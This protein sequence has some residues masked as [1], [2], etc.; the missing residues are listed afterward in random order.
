VENSRAAAAWRN[1]KQVMRLPFDT[2]Q[3]CGVFTSEQA[4]AAGWTKAQLSYAVRRDRIDRLRR[5]VYQAV[6]AFALSDHERARWVHA[7]QAIGAVLMTPGSAASHSAAAALRRMP[8]LF[9]PEAACMTVAPWFTGD[10][11]RVHVHR[12]GSRPFSLPVGS[13]ACTRVERTAID[14]AREHG[15]TAG[16]VALDYA[17]HTGMTD[18][19]KVLEDLE[20]CAR[21]PG[22]RQAREA[23]SLADGRS[24][25]VLESRSRLKLRE[26][27]VPEPDLQRSIGNEWG[28]FVARVDFY[29]DG[30]GVVGEADGA[31]KYDGTD[32]EPLLAEKKRQG[33]LEDLELEVVRWGSAD[34]RNFGPVAQRLNRAFSRG[35]R[36]PRSER[37]WTVLPPL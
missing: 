24:E 31:M 5:S 33:A 1:A 35:Q 21:W 3:Q 6:D 15:V 13:V 28:G 27:G 19:G 10:I 23:V 2:E 32:P 12:C 4:F 18:L 30:F 7:G 22:V 9:L 29:W 20:R 36:R 37:R 26:F 34:L 8:L 17:L 14:L 16:L 25:S 11:A